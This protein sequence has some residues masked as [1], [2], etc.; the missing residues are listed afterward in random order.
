MIEQVDRLPDW[1]FT[2]NELEQIAVDVINPNRY[3]KEADVVNLAV[4]LLG[5][6]KEERIEDVR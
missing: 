5:K 4:K 3:D 2:E 6:K 1:A